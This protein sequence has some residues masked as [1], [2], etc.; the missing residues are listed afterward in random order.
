MARKRL[1]ISVAATIAATTLPPPPSTASVANCAAP[2]K[3]IADITT[4]ASVPQPAV[5]AET[6]KEAPISSVGITS[7]KATRTPAA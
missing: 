5:D 4:G 2:E 6:P 7:G 3:T 1:A